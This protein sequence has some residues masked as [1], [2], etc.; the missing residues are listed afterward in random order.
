[1][2]FLHLFLLFMKFGILCVG[3]GYMLVPFLNA[4]LV[5]GYGIMSAETFRNLFSVA[6]VTPG[7][8]GIN[9]ATYVGY[10]QFGVPG[11]VAMSV[12]LVLP[13]L[14]LTTV[15]VYTLKRYEAHWA[16]RGFLAG[17]RPAT[18]GLIAGTLVIFAE[19][20]IFTGPLAWP[21]PGVNPGALAIAA[22]ACVLQFK[23]RV[24]LTW[25]ILGS[26]ALGALIC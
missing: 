14:I 21:P 10:T 26:A 22:T 20:S 11:A 12:A 18:V 8:I 4:E 5:E 2:S 9:A 13:S 24:T 1:M 3:G 16:V 23:T 17:V 19:M 25:L 6:Q 7:P 15:A